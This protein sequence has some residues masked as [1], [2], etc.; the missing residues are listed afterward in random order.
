VLCVNEDEAFLRIS[1]LTAMLKKA[2]IKFDDLNFT[3]DV[4]IIDT[5][6]PTRLK[7]GNF[8]VSYNLTSGYAK[9]EREIY[10]TNANMTNSFKLTLAYYHDTNKFITTETITIRASSFNDGTPTL[11]ELGIDVNKHRLDYYNN[12]IITNLIDMELTY[13]NLKMLQA[14]IINYTPMVYNLNVV[15]YM[16]DDKG[17]Y[18]ELL[19]RTIP[20]THPMLSSI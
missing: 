13:D 11:E 15:Y 19:T 6:Q 16:S 18:N 14:L 2:T 9:G 3:F 20:F 1:K 7:N 5:A 12:G 10:T 8:I 17:M 4:S